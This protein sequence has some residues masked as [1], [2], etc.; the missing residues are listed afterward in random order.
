M[1]YKHLALN[2]MLYI[3]YAMLHEENILF[4]MRWC[5]ERD[6]N[7]NHNKNVLFLYSL[8]CV[9]VHSIESC[10]IHVRSMTHIYYYLL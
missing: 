2:F 4:S 1:G 10:V 6:E 7:E 3:E 8:H 9:L 5:A